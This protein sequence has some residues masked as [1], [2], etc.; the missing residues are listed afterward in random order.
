MPNANSSMFT[1]IIE[2]AYRF[3]FA[4]RFM[5]PLN[6]KIYKLALR[7]IGVMNYET[8]RISGEASFLKNIFAR[9]GGKP[10]VLDVGANVGDYAVS[11]KSHYP[12]ARLYAFEP[13][14]LTFQKLAGK[15]AQY[16]FTA[17][18][19][20]CSAETG[21]TKF[22]DYAHNTGS[23]HASLYKDVF[24]Q[25]YQ[26]SVVEYDVSLTSLDHFFQSTPGLERINLLKIDTEGNEMRVLQGAE[27]AIRAGKIDVIYFEFNQMNVISRT[28][29]K[30]IYDLLR[31]Y[32]FYR[33]LPQSLVPM[34]SYDPVFFEIFVL[35]N[36]VAIRKEV[37]QQYVY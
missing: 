14:P 33:L 36:V 23:Q 15:A 16:G 32:E 9:T 12:Q 11:V 1:R 35:Q 29:F 18:Q 17:V 5:Y 10:L 13:H 19:Q 24:E 2:S 6:K 37:S 22:Y 27:G 26:D 3:V 7:G 28:F 25:I 21:T 31:G 4:R 34:G 8:P 20:A 30:D